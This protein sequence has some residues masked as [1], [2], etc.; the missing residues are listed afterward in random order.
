M[1]TKSILILAVSAVLAAG[2]LVLF[3]LDPARHGFYPLCLFHA[4]T[5]LHCPGCG[6]LRGAHL[7]LHGHLLEALQMNALVFLC[8]PVAA[9]F[10]FLK[11]RASAGGRDLSR[12]VIQPVWLWAALA[13][14][15]LF[16][17]LRNLPFYPFTLLA[18]SG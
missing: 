8:L 1:R 15:V 11:W 2:V 6:T 9:V 16:W 4:A 5:G 7:L 10:F 14:A 18:P 13:V 12:F 17:I 3:T